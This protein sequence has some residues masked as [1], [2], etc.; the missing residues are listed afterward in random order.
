MYRQRNLIDFVEDYDLE[1][2][3]TKEAARQYR[4]AAKSMDDWAGR[5]VSVNELDANTFNRW[6]RDIQ[7]SHLSPQTVL[8][9]RRHLLAMWRA[10]ADEGMC[11]EPPRRL[12]PVKAPYQ[13]PRAWTVEEVQAVL[14]VCKKLR[15]TRSGKIPRSTQW[16][17]AVRV[18]WESG[19]RFVDVTRL[20]CDDIQPDGLVVI[21]QSKTARPTI[22]RLSPSTLLLLQESLKDHPR[23]LACPWAS[24]KESFRRQFSLIV[25]RAGVRKGTWKWIRRS[26]ATDVEKACPGAGASHLGHAHGSTIAAKHYIDPYILGAPRVTPTPIN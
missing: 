17:L 21:G 12:R 3:L 13:A 20:K 24:S 18:A 26:S 9:R 15:R 11:D 25:S 1:R 10:A 7:E 19:M 5:N 6:L 23:K 16:S 4:Y 8:N 22:F 14:D 2:G